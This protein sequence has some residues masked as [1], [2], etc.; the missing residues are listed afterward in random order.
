MQ[1]VQLGRELTSICKWL[2]LVTVQSSQRAANSNIYQTDCLF[3]QASTC[4]KKTA[5]CDKVTATYFFSR[6]SYHFQL[7]EQT[8]IIHDNNE[9][10]RPIYTKI[11]MNQI[12][13]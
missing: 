6:S 9:K 3:T 2:P 1:T 8:D 10:T 12:S 4:E 5:K 13:Q 7:D 11:L